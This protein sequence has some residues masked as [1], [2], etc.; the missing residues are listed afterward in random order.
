MRLNPSDRF[1]ATAPL[2]SATGTSYTLYTFLSGGAVVLMDGFS[3]EAF[4]RLVEAE[5]VSGA[6]LFEPMVYDLKRSGLLSRHDLSSLRTGTGTPLTP[7]SFRWLIEDLGMTDFTNAYGMSET[8]NAA[9]RSFWYESTE[10]RVATAGQP[11]PGIDLAIVDLDS[12]RPAKPG[13]VG[14]IRI[15]SYT[16]MA[17]Y[18][19][20]E[21]E[22]ADAVDA[23]GWLHTGD[24]GELRPDGRLIFRG[25][26]K[27]M[28]KPGGFNVATLEIEDFIKTFPGVREAALVG[29]PDE[30][31][32]EVGYAFVE[33]EPGAAIDI[34]ALKHYCREH[35]AAFKIPRDIE[36]IT[37]WPRTST[38]KIQRLALKTLARDR[39]SPLP[40]E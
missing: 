32:G 7:K 6:F 40:S 9:C 3:P 29:V 12:N 38:G 5:R 2:F 8:S 19:K 30:R 15:R 31:L 35:I 10:D 21:K 24:L 14:E 36:L 13:E 11:L 37:D 34:G 20:M 23:D 18:Y 16:V 22:T 4:C 33:A 27:E 1:L 39:A 17:G 25:R 28:I 26:I